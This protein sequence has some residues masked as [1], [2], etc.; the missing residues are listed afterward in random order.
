MPGRGYG[1]GPG[2]GQGMGPARAG[3]PAKCVCPNCGYE[4][5]HVRGVPCSSETCPK[6]GT[7]MIGKW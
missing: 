5:E 4:K 3:G 2:R 7:R 6:C 1:R